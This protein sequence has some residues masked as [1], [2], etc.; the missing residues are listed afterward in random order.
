MKTQCT[1]VNE[2]NRCPKDD[3]R[4]VMVFDDSPVVHI[5]DLVF[6]PLLADGRWCMAPRSLK[7]PF[8]FDVS[9]WFFHHS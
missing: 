8:L 1:E 6:W 7:V 5:A 9:Q 3:L 2:I 4:V